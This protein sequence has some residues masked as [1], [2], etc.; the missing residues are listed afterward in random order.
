M[1]RERITVKGVVRQIRRGSPSRVDDCV[2]LI[3]PLSV[4][5]VRGVVIE[6]RPGEILDED[7]D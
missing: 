6:R 4:R 1:K 7:L 2:E 5:V 3:Q